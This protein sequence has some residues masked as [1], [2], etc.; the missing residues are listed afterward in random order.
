MSKISGY[1]LDPPTKASAL[2]V[3][4]DAFDAKTAKNVWIDACQACETPEEGDEIEDLDKVFNHLA[5]KKG[6]I[7]VYGMSLK[8]RMMTYKNILRLKQK[9]VNI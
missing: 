7:G 4:T 3:Y 5:S 8:V 2:A 9:G 6:P 1:N